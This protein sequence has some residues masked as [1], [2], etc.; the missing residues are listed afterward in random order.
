MSD[1]RDSGHRHGI[2]AIKSEAGAKPTSRNDSAL[3]S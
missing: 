1:G 2:R 3:Q